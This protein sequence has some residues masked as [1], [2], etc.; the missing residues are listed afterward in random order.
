MLCLYNGRVSCVCVL[1]ADD[2]Y[3]FVGGLG[4]EHDI[5]GNMCANDTFIFLFMFFLKTADY[6]NDVSLISYSTNTIGIFDFK[7]LSFILQI[8]NEVEENPLENKN[9]L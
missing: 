8:K 7:L 6:I 2:Y 5:L 1:Y 3:L 9:K 4:N